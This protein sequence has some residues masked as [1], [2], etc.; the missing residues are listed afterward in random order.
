M[1][2]LFIN[3][4]ADTLNITINDDKGNIITFYTFYR[5]IGQD[6]N[7]VGKQIIGIFKY[8][9]ANTIDVMI[10]GNGWEKEV[11]SFY[12]YLE[13]NGISLIYENKKDE[14]NNN[15]EKV[16]KKIS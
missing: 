10:S 5:M 1:L 12:N 13:Q 6:V 7:E 2:K 14:L 3:E 15:N 11:L 8:L 16:K 4:T 9:G